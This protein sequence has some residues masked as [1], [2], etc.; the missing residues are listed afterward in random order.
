MRNI[1]LTTILILC[2][3]HVNA[4]FSDIIVA[5]AQKNIGICIVTAD[6]ND[7]ISIVPIKY[8][9]IKNSGAL[10]AAVSYGIAKVKV[11][12]TYQG[13]K[14]PNR[15]KVGD[16]FVFKFG[17]IPLQF[18]QAYY[19]FAPSYSIKNFSLCKFDAK[20]DRRELTT[21]QASIWGNSEAGTSESNDISFD[22]IVVA[23]G[24]YEATITKA[25]PGEY[26]FVFADNGIGAY[27]NIFDFS[28]LPKT[29]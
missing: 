28:V 6:T 17:D 22:V 18:A 5:P 26:C 27:R 20:K 4:Q 2:G 13:G 25:S 12:C 16:K 3:L 11:K 7:S 29:K 21:A 1:V 24:V 15:V 14:S 8:T 10:A 19:M 9:K 23:P